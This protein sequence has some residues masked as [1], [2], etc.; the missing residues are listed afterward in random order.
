M[1][2]TLAGRELINKYLDHNKISVT[3]LA[4]MLGEKAQY[5]SS[6]LTGKQS[7]PAANELIL[8][9]IEMLKIRPEKLSKEV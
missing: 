5:V 4:T 3:S 6:V 7:N 2:A 8:Q 9:I 1:P